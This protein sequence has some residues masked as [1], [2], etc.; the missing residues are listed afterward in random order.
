MSEPALQLHRRSDSLLDDVARSFE[1]QLLNENFSP[2]TVRGYGVGIKNLFA[3]LRDHDVHDL[4]DLNRQL[5][6]D[7]Q[8]SLR[9]RVPPLKANSRGLYATSARQLIAWAAERDIVDLKLV[10]AIVRVRTKRHDED[11]EVPPIPPDDLRL[12]MAYLGPR[13]S[14]MTIVDLRDRAMFFFFFETGLRVSE[15]LQVRRDSYMSGRV[16]QKGGNWV[17]FE[18]TATVIAMIRD[19][20][21]ARTDDEPW[22][23]EKHGNNAGVHGRLQPSGVLEA[24]ARLARRLGI[25]RWKTHQIRHT[26][27]TT[28]HEEFHGDEITVAGVL[29]HSD[30]RTAHRYVKLSERSK[31]QM[32]ANFEAFI[33][34]GIGRSSPRMAP[35]MLERRSPRGGRPR[36]R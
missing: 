10:R 17:D 20:L 16:R 8:T 24:W 36:Y 6:E 14:R 18:I 1:Q 30:T 13:R 31:Q 32:L 3:F 7:W 5:L 4:A 2:E 35:E 27:G 22:L 9:E 19:Y 29:H 15:A 33:A 26:T 21:H 11:D 34:D 23:W 25:P 28:V 12:I